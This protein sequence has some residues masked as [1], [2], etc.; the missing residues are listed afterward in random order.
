MSETFVKIDGINI[1]IN[2]VDNNKIDIDNDI[3]P[4]K[5]KPITKIE[6][7]P[8]EKYLVTYSQDDHSIV[9]WNIEDIDEGRLNFD[10]TVKINPKFKS[11]DRI[12][13][14]DDK[15]LAFIYNDL[16]GLEI[17]DMN[18]DNQVIELNLDNS[19][20]E[21]FRVSYRY[22]T[23][24][25]KGEFIL[26]N[27]INSDI[28]AYKKHKIIW[29]YS[30]QTKNN[31]WMCKRIYEIPKD[32][33]L[34][35]I[36]KNDKLYLFSNNSIYEWNILNEE[37][38]RMFKNEENE[39]KV[40]GISS[41][42]NFTCLRIKDKIIIYSVEIG[43]S[44]ASLDIN[45]DIQIHNFMNQIN[46]CPLLLLSLFDYIPSC[47]IWNSITEHCWK[48]CLDRLTK[49][50][51]LP[52]E[53]QNK[54]LPIPLNNIKAASKYIFGI[55]DGYVWKIKLDEKIS[56]INFLFENSELN[57]KSDEIIESNKKTNKETLNV[58]FL[59]SYKDMIHTLFQKGISYINSV[60][61]KKELIQDL[62]TWNI[63]TSDGKTIKLQVFKRIE[64]DSK[65][66][67]ICT[68]IDKFNIQ[69]S[70]GFYFNIGFYEIKLFN[71][72]DIGLLTNMGLLIYRFNK[73]ENSISLIYF[74]Y[75]DLGL[76][77]SLIP[78]FSLAKLHYYKKVFS[79]LPL[80]SP[81]YVSFKL[82]DEWTLYMKENMKDKENLLKYGIELLTFAIKEHKLELIN[83]IYEKCII[84]Y[85]EDLVNNRIF[86]SIITS[87]MAVL[88]EYYP[89]YILKYSLETNMIIDSSFYNIE[90]QSNNLHLYSFQSLQIIN[91]T[92]S[93]L[94]SKYNKLL[95][96]FWKNQPLIII[97]L[98]IIFLTL[99][100]FPI[101]FFILNILF[102][103][104]FIN[105]LY[106][107][108]GWFLFFY[109]HIYISYEYIYSRS[110]KYMSTPTITFMIPYIKFVNYPQNY[111][112]L[113]EILIRPQPSPFVKTIS[114]DIYKTWNGEA[115]INFKWNT[116]GKYYYIIIW[117][118]FMAFLCCFTAAATISKQYID[119]NIR[120]QLLI[121]SIIF[122]FIHL[123]FEI[124][125]IIYNPIKWIQD[126]WNIFDIMA[127]VLPI[128]ASIYWLQTNNRN[129]SLLTF[130]CLFLDIKFLLFFRV[131]ESFGI[132]FAI[133]ISVGKQ[134]ISFLVVL[135]IILIS[136]AHAFYILL[137][138][139]S[140]YSF[141][142]HMNNDPNNPWNIVP[143]YNKV[144][145]D[146]T[147]DTH[148]FI[149]QSPDKNTNMF[150]DYRTSLFAMYLFLTGDSR[151]LSNWSYIDN[152]SLVILIFLFSLLIVVY[153]MN[154]FI[155]LLNNAIEK[156]NNRVS[157]LIQKAEILAEIE[158]FYLLPHQRRWNTWFPEVIYYYA[159]ADKTRKKIKEMIDKNEWYTNDFPELKQ[160]LLNKLNIQQKS[161]S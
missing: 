12:C 45:N 41:N 153:L 124:R 115:L 82:N 42:E 99:P 44:I 19:D 49:N 47:K 30:T 84:Y 156:D 96:K 54:I 55:L 32:F 106:G 155:G 16:N 148:P 73:S 66:D 87:T 1:D 125:Q 108:N 129:V 139:E 80:P 151:A 29:I 31:K 81:N 135:F 132:Y 67:L 91:L 120:K 149:I 145:D 144:F 53:Y 8:N 11:I 78:K 95:Y 142:K 46:L 147:I 146:G 117:I 140:D 131:F 14:S 10:H 93:I 18:N 7:S 134:I 110:S 98:L 102:K 5:N 58:H 33:E 28:T 103:Y 158:L 27:K 127:Y 23:F 51:Q 141:K 6:V 90:H 65:W 107:S 114:R 104:N 13:V 71:D 37:N 105:D 92:R 43:I 2:N 150:E 21:D 86:L 59:N 70:I 38:I 57:N 22:F 68:R 157:Y 88:N 100:G 122:G 61:S 89:E 137:S 112:W 34:I 72:D 109:A 35:G 40:D 160:E 130:S 118:T 126:F 24:N 116:Y 85:K 111:N 77:T 15:K 48:E 3:K 69:N 113:L 56:K 143:T 133:I 64:V 60:I 9:G 25:L 17:I 4:H 63:K 83:Y 97:E 101:I 26:Y 161:N 74:Y 123:S 62:V 79:K 50:F 20:F 128:Y 36:S 138:P 159:N 121:T 75:I 52:K 136:F 76:Y 39:W 119:E 152:P 94:W 154:L